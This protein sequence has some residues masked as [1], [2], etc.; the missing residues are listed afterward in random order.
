MVGLLFVLMGCGGGGRSVPSGAA[1]K[2]AGPF[3]D[4]H[5]SSFAACA[6]YVFDMARFW[7]QVQSLPCGGVAFNGANGG[8]V[9]ASLTRGLLV[10]SAR[11]LLRDA[12]ARAAW[13]R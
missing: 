10:T 8:I 5:D 2:P 3:V 9:L 13:P 12:C 4:C 1:A 7:G 11:S 6:A